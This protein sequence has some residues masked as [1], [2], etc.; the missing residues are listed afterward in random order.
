[1]INFPSISKRKKTTKKQQKRKKKAS[2]AMNTYKSALG[3]ATTKSEAKLVTSHAPTPEAKGC[4]KS[5]SI[6]I[7]FIY[8]KIR[9]PRS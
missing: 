7:R 3:T 5:A 6:H 4:A 8:Q 2:P 1:L 9:H